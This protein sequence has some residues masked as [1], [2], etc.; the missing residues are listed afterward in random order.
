M[1]CGVKR[2]KRTERISKILVAP[3]GLPFLEWFEAGGSNTG[4][5]LEQ[6]A[7]LAQHHA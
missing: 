1:D 2:N 5:P 6:L 7:H 3:K 4:L